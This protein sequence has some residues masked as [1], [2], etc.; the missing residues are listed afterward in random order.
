MWARTP[1]SLLITLSL[2]YLSITIT[3]LIISSA[4]VV[5]LTKNSINA[6]IFLVASYLLF[7]WLLFLIECEFFA[8]L[9]L[10][11][12]VGAVT[13]L[14]KLSSIVNKMQT[15]HISHY[16][17][18]FLVGLFF[19]DPQLCMAEEGAAEHYTLVIYFYKNNLEAFWVFT[20][21]NY[22]SLVFFGQESLV[23]YNELAQQLGCPVE[24][25]FFLT[26]TEFFELLQA[27]HDNPLGLPNFFEDYIRARENGYE[28]AFL[29]ENRGPYFTRE[30]LSKFIYD[31]GVAG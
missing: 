11:I 27:H 12:Y 21:K 28:A 15:S 24:E 17:F 2:N 30:A 8:L 23:P 7:L 3:F 16:T 25:G 26:F 6:I 29:E 19:F 4:L 13:L 10:I 1:F 9:I 18:V 22:P 20:E 31:Y 5:I 14:F